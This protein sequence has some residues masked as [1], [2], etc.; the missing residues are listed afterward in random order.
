MI[1]NKIVNPQE[2]RIGDVIRFIEDKSPYNHIFNNLSFMIVGKIYKVYSI[3]SVT[4]G[5]MVQGFG[6]R[7]PMLREFDGAIVG[8][9]AGTAWWGTFEYVNR[10][11]EVTI[12]VKLT[13]FAIWCKENYK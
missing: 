10:T 7:N 1:R 5:N 8:R 13:P 12:N 6:T 3:E 11:E 2:L 9:H 4:D